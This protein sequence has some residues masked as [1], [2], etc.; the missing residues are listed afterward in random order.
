[1]GG[2]C[3]NCGV[4]V[5]TIRG[6]PGSMTIGSHWRGCEMAND[7]LSG[8]TAKRI[9]WVQILIGGFLAEALLI[10][11]VIPISMKFGQTPLLYVAPVGSLVTCFLF[12]WW[13]GGRIESRV[14]LHGVLVGVVAML[15]YI[16]L[17]RARPE[18]LA[19]VMAHV[20]KLVG[21]GAGAWAAARRRA[22][23]A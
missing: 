19:Y 16:G 10:L 13:V 12:G 20:L 3:A 11:I 5:F 2:G 22:R 23:L 1:M 15:I 17:T 6:L 8:G 9:H 7:R 4:Q 21:G 14:V 18:P